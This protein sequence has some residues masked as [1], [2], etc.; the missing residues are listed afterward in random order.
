MKQYADAANLYK[1]AE[2]WDKAVALLL[3][4][5][6]FAAAAPLMDLITT[7]KLHATFAKVRYHPPTSLSAHYN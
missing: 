2:M 1:K 6:N 7:P 5:K 4:T 3:Q